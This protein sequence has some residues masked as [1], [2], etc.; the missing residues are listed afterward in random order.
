[1]YLQAAAILPIKLTV[2]FCLSSKLTKTR[3]FGGENYEPNKFRSEH[4]TLNHNQEETSE[5]P[6]QEYE[7]SRSGYNN[8]LIHYL[9]CLTR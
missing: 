5:I 2:L 8:P 7:A 6:I 1:M 3:P 4:K 9:F